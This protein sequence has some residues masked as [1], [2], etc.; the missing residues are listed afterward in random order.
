MAFEDWRTKDGTQNFFY[1][2]IVKT[3][4]SSNVFTAGA[5][6]NSSGNAD[7]F[8]TKKNASGVTL[9]SKQIN[10]TVNTHDFAAGMLISGADVY[11]TGTI[12][13]NTLTL[14]PE[15]FI[16]KYNSAGVQQYFTTFSNGYGDIGA[17]IVYNAFS[18][19][20]V[21]TG[22]SYDASYQTDIL[23]VAYDGSGSMVWS[24]TNDYNGL[25]DGGVKITDR[26]S[27]VVIT[28]VVSD[29]PNDYRLIS[30]SYTGV[31]GIF[32]TGSVSAIATSSVEI[33]SDIAKDGSGNLYICGATQQNPGQ[34]YD[35]YV[36]KVDN[37]LTILW[38]QTIDGG[39]NLNDFGK[40]IKLDGSGNVY[41]T[42]VTTHSTE[43]R[44]M[45]TIKLN[46]SGVVQ[47]AQNVNGSANGDDEGADMEIDG[48]GYIYVTGYQTV[49]AGNSDYYTCKYDGSGTKIWEKFMDGYSFNDQASSM[50]LDS[51]NNIVITGFAETDPNIY[52]YIT[53]K[54][55]QMDVKNPV[56][57]N[58]EPSNRNIGFHQNRGQI[59]DETGAST[60]DPLYYTHN[61]N[62]EIY[63]EKGS[64]D[65]VF[66]RMDTIV[67]NDDSLERINVSFSNSNTAAKP[68]GYDPKSY[69]LHYLLGD[70]GEP[71]SNV[72]G[73]DRVITKDLYPFID[74]HYYSNAKGF[75]YYFV[76]NDGGDPND[77]RLRIDG[78]ASNTITA[79]NLFI[80]GVLGDV[81][82]K[83]PLAYMVDG[84][85]A[86]TT[87][88]AASYVNMGSNTYSI[89]TPAYTATQTLIIVVETLPP[90]TVSSIQSNLD[91]STYYGGNMAD[92]FKDI[93]VT[94]NGDRVISGY[95][96]GGTFPT[97]TSFQPIPFPIG[98]YDAVILKYTADDTLRYC[99]YFGAGG[100]DYGNSVAINSL[101]FV[102]VGGQTTSTDLFITNN[103]GETNQ[104][105]NGNNGTLSTNPYDGFLVKLLPNGANRT[106]CRY[107]GGQKGEYLNAIYIDSG[108]NLYI[109]G[110]TSSGDFPDVNAYYPV[111]GSSANTDDFD[112][113]VGKIN[114]N[115]VV[116]WLTY[117]GGNG[118]GVPS[119]T[120]IESGLDIFTDN[121]NN[122]WIVGESDE[123]V[124]FPAT[125]PS[126]GN[127]NVLY[128]ASNNGSV[129]GFIAR[130]TLTGTPDYA[131]FVGGNS[132][133]RLTR[134]VYDPTTGDVYFA[135]NAA[136]TSGFPWK[137]KS[138]AYYD[139]SRHANPAT[140][141]G[142]MNSSLEHQWIT[143]YGHGGS[144]K[145]YY[146]NGLS[147]DNAGLIY[148]S[149]SANSDTLVYGST[150][151]SGA[152]TDNTVSNTDGFIAVF[153]VNKQI[154]HAH[155]FGGSSN[156]FI[157]NSDCNGNYNLYVVGNTA[158]ANFPIAYTATNAT[159]IDSTY[160]G[161]A[162]GFISRFSLYPY[163][164]VGM[165]ENVILANNVV[166]FPN[167]TNN[168]VSLK[169]N[170]E[171][172]EKV[173]L[174]VYNS[175]GQIVH[176]ETISS[177]EQI[178]DCSKWA[179][180][181][182]IF[183]LSNKE[184]NSSFKIIRE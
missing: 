82:L 19:N 71:V 164:L 152:Y 9:W 89:T 141:I 111:Q 145:N 65:Y 126:P 56:D 142:Y 170:S 91:Y 76:V 55:V 34:G 116:Q 87:L 68:Y 157:A 75:K 3:D 44:N 88:S 58:G 47:W 96:A 15:M 42:G 169:I 83:R 11:I 14:V 51:L 6:I 31:T 30:I 154:Y 165:Q 43:G 1:K 102:F 148:M 156:D 49:A 118:N 163:N 59:R 64:Y 172:K 151:P 90:T 78:S 106:Y 143:Y 62:P 114:S 144:A 17:D 22:A 131:T 181:M 36:A 66:I 69:P 121:S 28:G 7:I 94:A 4:G 153:D 61:L 168:F 29:A 134:A 115:Q 35:Y 46:S 26:G 12:T 5:T 104:A 54:Y 27:N 95:S 21:V 74:L 97:F 146:V 158:S 32:T 184:F 128:D 93:K 101:G 137:F 160:N 60:T 155:Y 178:V 125:N 129:D 113:F 25:N 10:G 123:N 150:T 139:G 174:K 77:I 130:F 41:L 177:N 176:E 40:A 133:D 112:A 13:N 109:T 72:R 67:A 80:G 149:G 23:T 171:L 127:A 57:L 159:L 81:T 37:T 98:I 166:A 107:V 50:A 122:V 39:S 33:V 99:T 167:P 135:G 18:G 79:N 63:L 147:R 85:G 120:T 179:S 138:G 52:S 180:G 45:T 162:D 53:T 84:A 110:S 117:F 2:N 100:A 183:V 70:I 182:Y 24:G 16:A 103:G 161:S 124:S 38:E 175:V 108:D 173:T 119:T 73:N 8:L 105:F 136:S 86:T 140:F 20:I 132:S 48:S 92:Y